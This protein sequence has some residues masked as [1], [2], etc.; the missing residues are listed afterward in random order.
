LVIVLR[1]SVIVLRLLVI[2]LRLLVIVLRLS[3]IVLRLSVNVQN[4]HVF[5]SL[6]REI[7]SVSFPHPSILVDHITNT[8]EKLDLLNSTSTTY[9]TSTESVLINVLK[10]GRT[11]SPLK[12]VKKRKMAYSDAITPTLRRSTRSQPL[13]KQQSQKKKLY[14]EEANR[15]NDHPFNHSMYIYVYAVKLVCIW[16]K[17]ISI[18][19]I[20]TVSSWRGSSLPNQCL[21]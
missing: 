10:P 5:Y 11:H 4:L 14:P 3:V 13:R 1:L 9:S 15:F 8:L 6:P 18:S 21:R 20:H 7:L 16:T 12:S 2:V 17:S 19:P